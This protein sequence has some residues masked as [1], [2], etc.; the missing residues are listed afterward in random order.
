MF[1][2]FFLGGGGWAG[3]GMG[4]L[5]SISSAHFAFQPEEG[6]PAEQKL[7]VAIK[8]AGNKFNPFVV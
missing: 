3:G 8:A 2:H 1:T 6:G 7:L 5:T 4:K